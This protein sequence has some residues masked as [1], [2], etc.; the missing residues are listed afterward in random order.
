MQVPEPACLNGIET[1]RKIDIV[2]NEILKNHS[3][4]NGESSE[5][6]STY[7]AYKNPSL[8]LLLNSPL[9]TTGKNFQI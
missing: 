8:I 4:R 2:V 6:L 1:Q 5:M 9:R 3:Y 7:F